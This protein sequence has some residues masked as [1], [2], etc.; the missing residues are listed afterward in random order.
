MIHSDC[1]L[2]RVIGKYIIIF[3]SFLHLHVS[4][5]AQPANS[6]ILLKEVWIPMTDGIQLAADLYLPADANKKRYPVVLEYLPYR[7]DEGRSN[8]F[9]L[10]SYFV[11][12]GYIIARVDIRGTGRSEGKLVDGEYSEQEQQ[13][14]E[15]VI[16]WLAKQEFSTGKLAM[17]GISWGGF[18]SLHLAMRKPPA[19]KTI[20]SL[21]S[22]DDIYEDDVHF[23][24]GIMHIDAYEIGQD[25]TNILPPAPDFKIDD[26]YFSNRFDT[27]PWLLKYKLQQ[28][29]GPFWNRASLNEDYSRI[30]VPVF[31]IG[32]WYDGYRDFIPR[33]LQHADVPVKAMIGPWNHTWP[34]WAEPAPAIEWREMTVRWL[35]HWLKGVDNGI[36]K[37]PALYYYQRD[38][39][40]PGS[41]I[42]SIPGKWKQ[43]K[44]WPA[45]SE[46]MY[47]LQAN[48]QLGQTPSTFQ[49]HLQYK[50]T[51]G[52]EASGSVM[53]WGDWAPDQQGADIHSLTYDSNPMDKD[54][55]IIGFP[56]VT[57][58]TQAT[59]PAA[60][61]IVRLSDVAPDGQVTQVTG[62]AF[63]ATHRYSS[64]NPTPLSPDSTYQLKIELHVTSWTFL[65]GHKIRVAI[66]NAQWPMFWPT[67]YNMTT[68]L[69][70][71]KKMQSSIRIPVA[72]ENAEDLS[73]PF[74]LP[75]HD[76]VLAGYNSLDAE[77]NSGFAEIKEIIRN[78][79]TQTTKVIATNSGRDQYPWGV[80]SYTEEIVHEA[81]DADPASASV[82]SKYS[83]THETG[84]EMLT[85]SGK[86]EFTS[87]IKNY[88]Y[89]YTRYLEKNGKLLREKSWQRTIPRD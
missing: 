42:D 2:T 23:M 17:F 65:K 16:D 88:Y 5:Q 22:T 82:R 75:Q 44:Q 71:N 4:L 38:W 45:V 80:S 67:P 26:A 87:D 39:H 35:D 74:P 27:E 12:R 85:W 7:K 46:Q 18:N 49:H 13:D 76:P 81:S 53:W 6:E 66:S 21:M 41:D 29:D 25:L 20:L 9:G 15:R 28:H 8:R 69:I 63:N 62:A 31:V 61:W 70:S 78:E 32:G 56:S 51:V 58:I 11:K 73:I 48:H 68:T 52:V 89:H 24:D 37:E 50:P 14:G 33:L 30:D 54:L 86:L 43:G 19:L 40:Q 55:E 77:T 59:A 47:F 84:T 1:N 34:N 64:V 36:M 72:P 83:I 79:R 10:Y 57:L 60:N 3:I